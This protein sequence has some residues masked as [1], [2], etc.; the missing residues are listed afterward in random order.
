MSMY[1]RTCGF[2][3]T[4]FPAT[5]LTNRDPTSPLLRPTVRLVNAAYEPAEPKLRDMENFWALFVEFLPLVLVETDKVEK[6]VEK[7]A[8]EVRKKAEKARKRAKAEKKAAAKAAKKAAK[9]AAK[10]EKEAKKEAAAKASHDA[11]A[12]A[13]LA[14]DLDAA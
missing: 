5:V 12:A 1:L 6:D 4:T 9:E 3:L 13:D 10:A 8:K 7:E 14:E 11:E 2:G